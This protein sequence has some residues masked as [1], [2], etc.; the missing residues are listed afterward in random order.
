MEN[1]FAPD[2]AARHIPKCATTI[3]RPKPPPSSFASPAHQR[4]NRTSEMRSGRS[5]QSVG[6]GGGGGGGVGGGG[7]IGRRGANVNAGYNR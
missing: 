5:S 3:N 4:P 2:V 1:R 6:G 7:V